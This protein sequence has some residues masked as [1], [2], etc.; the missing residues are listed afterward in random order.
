MRKTSR[1]ILIL[2]FITVFISVLQPVA[3]SAQTQDTVSAESMDY[4]KSVMEMIKQKYNGQVS[5]K[6]L[7]EGALKGMFNTMDPYTTYFTNEEAESFLGTMEGS[8]GGIGI[9][10]VETE[11]YIKAAGIFPDSPAEKA[12]LVAGDL[13]VEV[14]GKD[15]KGIGMEK[16]SSMIKGAPGTDVTLGILRNKETEI[17]RIKI[18]R[19][20]VK[21]D[22]GTYFIQ[23][24]IGYIRLTMFT[25]NAASFV[26]RALGEMDKNGVTKLILDLRDNPGG[27]VDQA[28]GV[29]KNFV[30]EGIITK[31]DFKSESMEDKVYRSD[32]KQAKYKLVV[33]VNGDSASAS[34]I[35]AGAIQDTKSGILVGTKTFGK[36]RVQT[37]IPVLTP[38]AFKKY[39]SKL[40]VKLVDAYDLYTRFGVNPLE[41]EVV[42]W[43]K[44]TTGE[45][46]TPNGRMIDKKGI[47]PDVAINNVEYRPGVD[48]SGIR[49]L[50]DGDD[51][52]LGEEDILNAE[53]I[54]KTL[55]YSIEKPDTLMDEETVAALK[56]Y[57][58]NA[59]IEETG[60]L[61][62]ATKEKLNDNL[63]TLYKLSD[64]QYIK[65]L[66]I[67]KQ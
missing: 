53:S 41:D 43:T 62:A 24:G 60:E 1:N 29:A 19:D 6:Q 23:E 65:A 31:L 40:G 63:N 35:V 26:N 3:A 64:Y 44:I 10:M 33:L 5:D 58:K 7:I 21:L 59:L 28:V 32:L 16:A 56:N 61:D 34:E 20:I 18:T 30:P 67:L 54:L 11:G 50:T 15:I 9:S 52:A 47:D 22:P 25:A 39:E 48:A 55:G 4:L 45:Y 38:E 14:D 37:L 49:K 42:G 2:C 66:E 36:A 17:Q 13:I 27:E 46:Y 51:I 8:Y 57:Q 12:G